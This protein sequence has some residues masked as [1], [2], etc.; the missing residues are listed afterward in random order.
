MWWL[1]IITQAVCSLF[2]QHII[3]NGKA[4]FGQRHNQVQASTASGNQ[5]WKKL[6]GLK[7]PGKIKIFGWRALKGLIPCRAILANRH[8]GNSGNCPVCM[9]GA[10]D[11]KHLLFTCDRARDVW[12]AL[13]VRERV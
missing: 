2:A 7:V 10:E 4:K 6:W 8:V 9:H 12:Q 3:A 13:G 11:I 5:L 1:G